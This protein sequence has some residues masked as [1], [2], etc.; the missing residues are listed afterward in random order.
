MR[1]SWPRPRE[2]SVDDEL[3]ERKS[4]IIVNVLVLINESNKWYAVHLALLS[5]IY[6][7]LI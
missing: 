7:T 5:L 1:K 4:V 3:A 2:C 6:R